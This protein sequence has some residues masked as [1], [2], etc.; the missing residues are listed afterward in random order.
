MPASS[1]VPLDKALGKARNSGGPRGRYREF[2]SSPGGRLRSTFT[3]ATGAPRIGVT[4]W[5]KCLPLGVLRLP[6]PS[7]GQPPA[8]PSSSP[9]PPIAASPGMCLHFLGPAGGFPQIPDPWGAEM[10]SAP[11]R[12]SS[13][14]DRISWLGLW[15][16]VCLPFL[17]KNRVFGG[18][19]ATPSSPSFLGLSEVENRCPEPEHWTNRRMKEQMVCTCHGLVF[20]DVHTVCA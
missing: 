20:A 16:P 9:A 18:L 11:N 8:V 4:L 10:S 6:P 13:G 17:C 7:V 15:I 14:W 2:A 1:C 5:E 3:L 19:W 12:G